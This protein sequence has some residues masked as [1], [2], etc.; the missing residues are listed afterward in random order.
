MFNLAF[1]EFGYASLVECSIPPTPRRFE[2]IMTDAVLAH[3]PIPGRAVSFLLL[4]VPVGLTLCLGVIP[5]CS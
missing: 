5:W 4:A 3:S 1:L 2:L